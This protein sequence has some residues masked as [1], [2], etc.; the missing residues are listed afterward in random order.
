M[1]CRLPNCFGSPPRA[2]AVALALACLL[3]A[4]VAQEKQPEKADEK[5]EFAEF[6]DDAKHYAI[7]A[8]KPEAALKLHESAVLNFTNPERNQERGSVFVWLTDDGR[9]AVVGQFFRFDNRAGRLKKHALHSLL[10]SPIEAKLN[11]R[12]AW[13]PEEA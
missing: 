1:N 5:T 12:L 8:A 13:A 11:D 7:R 9:P 2:V 6:L 3:P 4:G 10:G